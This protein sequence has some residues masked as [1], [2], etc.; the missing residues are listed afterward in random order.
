MR[1]LTLAAVVA[2]A[3]SIP[4]AGRGSDTPLQSASLAWDRGDYI[5]ALTTYLEVLKGSP[6]EADLEAIALQ[7]GELFQTT[8]LTTDGDAPQFSRDSRYIAY[9]TGALPARKVRVVA[10]SDPK[11]VVA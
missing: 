11:K 3:L 5:A 1:K 4:L 9:E 8:E 10:T 6:A 7:T 2:A